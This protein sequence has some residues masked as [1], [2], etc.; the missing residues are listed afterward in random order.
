ML[1][2]LTPVTLGL[3]YFFLM[4]P[5]YIQLSKWVINTFLLCFHKQKYYYYYFFLL[6]LRSIS[7]SVVTVLQIMSLAAFN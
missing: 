6:Y 1:K 4:V 7:F 5:V 3:A 2:F